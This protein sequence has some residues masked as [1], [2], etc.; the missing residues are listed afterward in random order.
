MTLEANPTS[1]EAEKLRGFKAAGVN[2]VSLGV[3]A[4]RDEALQK[5]WWWPAQEAWFIAK[6]GEYADKYKA[7]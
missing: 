6:R 3:Q 2:R 5:L 7:S 1:V 4:L